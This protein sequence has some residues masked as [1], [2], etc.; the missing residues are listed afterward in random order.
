MKTL[1]TLTAVAALIAGMSVASAQMTTPKSESPGA[2]G[3]ATMGSGSKQVT[4]TA[5]YCLAAS[6]GGALNCKYASLAACQKD[7]TATG[8]CS[9]NPNRG[10][11]GSS[12]QR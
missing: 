3:S 8:Q 4:G 11:T 2:S 5:Q 10:T 1:T 12:P 7:A 6:A 9:P